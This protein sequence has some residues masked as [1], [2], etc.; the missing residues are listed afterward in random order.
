MLLQDSMVLNWQNLWVLT[1]VWQSSLV[2]RWVL[3]KERCPV[4][5]SIDAS[6]DF[7]ITVPFSEVAFGHGIR[8]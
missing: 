4:T 3:T 5:I 2:F 6:G 7:G 1:S 8:M